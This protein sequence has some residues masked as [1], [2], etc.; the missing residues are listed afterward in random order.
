M[1]LE[2][3]MYKILIRDNMLLHPQY[4]TDMIKEKKNYQNNEN[5]QKIKSLQ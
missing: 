2:Y 1:K 4:L 3:A 5:R